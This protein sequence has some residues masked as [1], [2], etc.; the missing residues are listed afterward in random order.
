[1]TW[2]KLNLFTALEQY[3]KQ[4]DTLK[5]ELLKLGN[6]SDELRIHQKQFQNEGEFVSKEIGNLKSCK[7]LFLLQD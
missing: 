4:L 5:A 7:I 1:M 2:L 3:C 6:H